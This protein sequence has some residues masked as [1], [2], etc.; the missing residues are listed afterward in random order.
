M[1]DRKTK[2]PGARP[3][4]SAVIK[5]KTGVA[6]LFAAAQYSAQGFKRLIQESAFR[7]ELLGFVGGL[8][9]FAVIGASLFEFLGF[10]VLMMLMFSV[11]AL[12]TAIEEL[13]DRISPEISTVGRNAKDLGSFAVFC[14]IIANAAFA[15]YVVGNRL[16]FF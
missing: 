6:H 15:I 12:N 3:L 7:H 5:K 13:V 1:S 2:N 10:I 4:A 11:E 9:V 16:V 14:L 8:V